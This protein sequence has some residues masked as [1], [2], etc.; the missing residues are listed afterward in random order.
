MMDDPIEMG[1]EVAKHYDNSFFCEPNRKESTME[2]TFKPSMLK[3]Q[4]SEALRSTAHDNDSF[5]YVSSKPSNK[6]L[7]NGHKGKA[8]PSKRHAVSQQS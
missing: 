4:L 6:Q 5:G 8:L 7:N 3:E 1:L 2:C